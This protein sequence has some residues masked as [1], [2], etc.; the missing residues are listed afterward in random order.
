MKIKIKIKIKNKALLN[1]QFCHLLIYLLLCQRVRG[2]LA[3]SSRAFLSSSPSIKGPETEIQQEAQK[4][5]TRSRRG[6][7]RCGTGLQ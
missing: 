5:T 1:L 3:P 7:N 2:D 6:F 4:D